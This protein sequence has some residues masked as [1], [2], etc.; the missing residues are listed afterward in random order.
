MIATTNL[1]AAT[2]SDR[3]VYAALVDVGRALGLEVAYWHEGRFHF[4]FDDGWSV[5]ISPES[6]CRFRLEACRWTRPVATLWSLSGDRERLAALV[7]EMRDE[8][9]RARECA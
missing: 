6:A 9:M 8:V 5:A 1:T 4:A 3:E 7:L 2:P